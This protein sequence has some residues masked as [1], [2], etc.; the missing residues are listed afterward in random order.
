MYYE[1]KHYFWHGIMKIN[2]SRPWENISFLSPAAAPGGTIWE[3]P[4]LARAV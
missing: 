4:G 2:V 3:E 1:G